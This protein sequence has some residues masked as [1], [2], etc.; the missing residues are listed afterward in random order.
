MTGVKHIGLN[1]LLNI[2][3]WNTVEAEYMFGNIYLQIIIR[4]GPTTLSFL[5]KNIAFLIKN[6]PAET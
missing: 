4:E 5:A 3:C 2:W 1:K 6:F